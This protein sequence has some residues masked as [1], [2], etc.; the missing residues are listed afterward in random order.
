MSGIKNR[1]IFTGDNLEI[2]R[3]F[4]NEFVDLIYLDPPFN[5]KHNYAAPIGSKAAGAAFKDTWTLQDVDVS[6][7]GEIAETNTAL[8]KALE[9]AKHTAGKSAM[10]YLIYMAIRILEMHRILKSTGSL[11][12]HC[13]Q[14]MSHY[15]KMVLDAIFDRDHFRNE[16]VWKRNNA[17][18]D[19]KKYGRITDSILFYSKSNKYIW[20]TVYVPYS[21]EFILKSFRHQ[22]EKGKYSDQQLTAQSLQGGGYEYEFHGHHRVWKRSLESMQ[23]LEKDGKIHFPKKGLGI[24]RYKLYLKDALGIPLQ[25]VWT[26]IT[27][28]LGN[29]RLGYPTQKPLALL[30]RIIQAST[31]KDD[32]ILD[33]FCGCATACSAAER[34]NR[35]W[36]G[37]DI[38]PK[39]VELMNARMVSEA[40]I[41]K[42]TKGAGVVIQRTDIPIRK[43]NRS[44]NIK[45]QLFGVQEGRCNLCRHEIEFRHMEV[46]HKIPKARGGPDDDGNLQLLCGHCNRVKGK[47]TMAEAK[48]RLTKLGIV[49]H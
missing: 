42:W 49:A 24:P 34:L 22:D 12:L 36:I 2:L 29:E 28:A 16:I 19:G 21:E 32:M 15:L 27:M 6:W 17:H 5:S 48:V 43:G 3:G 37:I 39:A 46:D 26:D 4:P 18:N 9:A 25:N 41:E 45:H 11:Y 13:D 7:W 40:G 44:K 33:P 35:K 1:T 31:R 10:S 14:T 38:S 23:Q 47:G 20:N 8:Y 30:E